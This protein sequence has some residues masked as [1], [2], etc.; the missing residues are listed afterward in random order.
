MSYQATIRNFKNCTQEQA[1]SLRK[2]LA[3]TMCASTVL[4]CAAYYKNAEKRDPFVEEIRM[5][6]LLSAS[7]ERDC[8]AIA[9]TQFYTNDEFIARTYADLLNKRK[10][11]SPDATHPCTIAEAAGL[12][13]QY[14]L[15]TKTPS[16]KNEFTPI[17]E[18]VRD[19]LFSASLNA[20]APHDSTYRLRPFSGT[21]ASPAA[22]DVLILLKP[23]EKQPMAQFQK[24]FDLLLQ[25]KALE[26]CAKAVYTVGND[27][28]LRK[29]LEVTSGVRINLSSLTEL[30][31]PLPMTALCN[32]Y[33]GCRMLRVGVKDLSSATEQLKQFKLQAIPFAQITEDHK[34]TFS[35]TQNAAFSIDSGF[36]NKLYHYKPTCAKLSEEKAVAPSEIRYG[37]SHARSCTYL[38]ADSLHERTDVFFKN[39]LLSA[40]ASASPK[41][42]FFKTAL[43]TALLP[44][45][46]LALNGIAP[47]EQNLSLAMELPVDC[48]E[49]AT[50]GNCMA[51][52]LGLYRAQIELGLPARPVILRSFSDIT[53]PTVS[54]F[55]TAHGKQIPEHFT[56]EGNLVYCVAPKLDENG[57]PDFSALRQM[58]EQLS[59]W[60][61]N[62][63]ITAFRVLVDRSVT[64][65]ILK[66][67]DAYSCR[68]SDSTLAADGAHSLLILLESKKKL[69]LRQVGTVVTAP[70][71][72]DA[73]EQVFIP[74]RSDLIWSECPDAVVL[75]K[76][77]DADATVLAAVLEERG[78][79]VTLYTDDAE[80]M[81]PLS[82]AILTAQY[83][84]VCKR[85]TLIHTKQIDF[86]LETLRASGGTILQFSDKNEP[87]PNAILLKKGMDGKVLKT[88]CE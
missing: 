41:S 1:E 5:L 2:T 88:I 51:S 16:K 74:R 67:K 54:A 82:R 55:V 35:R 28:I 11:L 81:A 44:V 25:S 68:L 40:A 32:T 66:M 36:L 6:D 62:G 4:Y 45:I 26:L 3:L 7:L 61:R 59:A 86:A 79:H 53:A 50:A 57:M 29:L 39:G 60:S 22:N 42:A 14:L 46:A 24:A 85:A 15:R 48:T 78:A 23:Q 43:Y 30:G 75:A 47:F 38:D 8:H 71:A 84:I 56:N 69:P 72:V 20:I 13:A 77:A 49:P 58:L 33:G 37:C 76:K 10:E 73:T 9:P 65:G 80:C 83:L 70:Q 27:G 19:N 31:I 87:I 52:V 12:A 17:P 64:D 18:N 34:F 63:D 21:F